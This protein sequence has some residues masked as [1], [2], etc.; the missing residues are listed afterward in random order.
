[1]GLSKAL[2]SHSCSAGRPLSSYTPVLARSLM[3]TMPILTASCAAVSLIIVLGGGLFGAVRPFE[4]G[5][6]QLEHFA[7]SAAL[8]WRQT[9]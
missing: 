9:L 6:D 5:L 4:R 1:M 2:D 7:E 3:E 8:A